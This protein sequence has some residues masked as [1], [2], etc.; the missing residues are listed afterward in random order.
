MWTVPVH[1]E[2]GLAELF[3]QRHEPSFGAHLHQRSE[4]NGYAE[5]GSVE[6]GAGVSLRQQARHLKK[7]NYIKFLLELEL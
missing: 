1:E 7:K 6:F 4:G 5:L 3:L 2:L